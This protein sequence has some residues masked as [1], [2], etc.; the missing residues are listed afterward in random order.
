MRRQF[1]GKLVGEALEGC[2]GGVSDEGRES[3]QLPC[4][5]RLEMLYGYTKPAENSVSP[6]E[7]EN[8]SEWLTCREASPEI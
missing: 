5:L 2:L 8:E 6:K 3:Y 7:C 4:I 1:S